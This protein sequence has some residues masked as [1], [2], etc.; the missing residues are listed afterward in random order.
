MSSW[1]DLRE[2]LE[3]AAAGEGQTPS[4]LDV[5]QANLKG[6]AQPDLIELSKR[7]SPRAD[8][9]QEQQSAST[10]PR[11]RSMILVAERTLPEPP[12]SPPPS[13]GGTA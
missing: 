10:S 2:A 13:T 12:T 5:L 7:R 9:R 6:G 4:G 3:A 1:V 11:S 8:V